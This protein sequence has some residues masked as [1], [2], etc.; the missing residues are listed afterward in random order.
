MIL[1]FDQIKDITVGAHKIWQ[2][3]NGVIAFAKCTDKQVDAWNSLREILGQRARTTTGIRFDLHTDA[4]AVKFTLASGAFDLLINGVLMK[5]HSSSES[6]ELYFE[7][8]GESY[9]EP[10]KF[11]KKAYFN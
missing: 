9:A 11:K 8:S 4:K 2:G 7:L 3:E 5:K 10:F 1:T 6:K